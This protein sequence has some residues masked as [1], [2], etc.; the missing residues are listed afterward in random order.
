[1]QGV[2]VTMS[3]LA[4]YMDNGITG[5]RPVIDRTGLKGLFTINTTAYQGTNTRPDSPDSELPTFSEL[6]ARMG[7]ELKPDTAPVEIYRIEH[8]E[9]PTAN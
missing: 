4:R 1:M 8:I 5:D 7:L 9:K 6:L 3:D 2:A